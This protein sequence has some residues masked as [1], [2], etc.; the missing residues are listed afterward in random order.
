MINSEK[1]PHQVTIDPSAINN[2]TAQ[3]HSIN[4]GTK[5]R[6]SSVKIANPT[7]EFKSTNVNCPFYWVKLSP[8]GTPPF[9]RA[10]HTLVLTEENKFYIY[11][12]HDYSGNPM[13]DL[14]CFE[15]DRKLWSN[16]NA[17]S[18]VAHKG[19]KYTLSGPQKIH[20]NQNLELC[21]LPPSRAYHT[22]IYYN[23]QMIVHGGNS[24]EINGETYVLLL[25]K[26]PI[27]TKVVQSNLPQ[28]LKTARFQHSAEKWGNFMVIYGGINNNVPFN[29]LLLFDLK[30]YKWSVL[31]NST[32]PAI[33]SHSCFI[34]EDILFLVG[35]K[36]EKGN[37]S[38]F[39]INLTNGNKLI[40]SSF[41]PP[42]YTINLRLMTSTYDPVH[43]RLYVFGGYIVDSEEAENGCTMQID[44]VDM[45]RKTR[46][47]LY[48]PLITP[49]PTPRCGHTSVLYNGHL[50]VFGGCDRLPLLDGRWV[51]CDFSNTIWEFVPPKPEDDVT[52]L[53]F[54]IS[55]RD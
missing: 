26:L 55:Q 49:Y 36:G 22:A 42:D 8:Y 11:G 39:A 37:N 28:E 4:S 29:H 41:F 15:I 21:P 46:G 1:A 54:M 30:K 17:N 53:R 5:R 6:K 10:N 16:V 52:K 12:G 2:I 18:I 45:R 9:E 27:W 44:I 14:F 51:Y 40:A 48:S 38:F 34:R 23:K 7:T 20:I 50:M 25:D 43:D 47:V 24:N 35:G 31:S 3:S 19:K 32:F 13:N 33:Y